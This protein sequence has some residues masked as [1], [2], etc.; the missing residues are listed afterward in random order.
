MSLAAA[1]DLTP[2]RFANVRWVVVDG[3]H[4]PRYLARAAELE[5]AIQ[6]VAAIAGMTAE[7]MPGLHG[8]CV[9]AAPAS[10]GRHQ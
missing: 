9:A 2:A 1:D 10:E 5:R 7:D 3:Q 8:L 4:Q 6:R